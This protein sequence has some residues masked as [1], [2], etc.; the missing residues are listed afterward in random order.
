ML[1]LVLPALAL[2]IIGA[3]IWSAYLIFRPPPF[4]SVEEKA[5]TRQRSRSIQTRRP[6]GAALG[7][8]LSVTSQMGWTDAPGASAVPLV[9]P[10]SLSCSLQA[11]LPDRHIHRS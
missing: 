10:L 1:V 11:N 4:A 6:R 7:A 5:R 2:L 9:N 8:T 3:I